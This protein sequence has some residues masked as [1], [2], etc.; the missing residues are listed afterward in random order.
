MMELI[1]SARSACF[2]ELAAAPDGRLSGVDM[3]VNVLVEDPD[4]KLLW[5]RQ[6][7]VHSGEERVV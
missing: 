6:C 5:H 4:T 7:G 3:D 1:V 2:R